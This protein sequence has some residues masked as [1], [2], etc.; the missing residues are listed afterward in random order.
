MLKKPIWSAIE[1]T[2]FYYS[3]DSTTG[4]VCTKYSNF[5]WSSF[6]FWDNFELILYPRVRNSIT[7]LTIKYLTPWWFSTV[8]TWLFGPFL[9]GSNSSR[10]RCNNEIFKSSR[11]EEIGKYSGIIYISDLCHFQPWK[12]NYVC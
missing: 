8:S 3:D 10:L 11:W 5:P 2:L 12:V 1:T 6:I 9:D 4:P 7:Q